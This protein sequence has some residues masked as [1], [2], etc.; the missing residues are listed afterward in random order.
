MSREQAIEDE[1]LNILAHEPMYFDDVQDE[2]AAAA[3]VALGY[4][5]RTAEGDYVSTRAGRAFARA[6][7]PW[8]LIEVC[9]RLLTLIERGGAWWAYAKQIGPLLG[10]KGGYHPG[11]GFP[12]KAWARAGL[13][14]PA[15]VA[16][17]GQGAMIRVDHLWERLGSARHENAPTLRRAIS[18]YVESDNVR[19]ALGMIPAH[20]VVLDA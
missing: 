19:A 13:W 4:A 14:I 6:T 8:R 2:R 10:Y 16:G 15:K 18:P 17:R 9:D 3:V 20:D 1:M 11:S 7:W 12:I 5:E